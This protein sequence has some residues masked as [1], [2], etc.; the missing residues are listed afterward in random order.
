M[1]FKEQAKEIADRMD[2]DELSYGEVVDALYRALQSA[3][4]RGKVEGLKDAAGIIG[5][6]RPYN[7][8][9]VNRST[10]EICVAFVREILSRAAAL[11]QPAG[12]P[13]K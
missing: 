1:D 3:F 11:K 10:Q 9:P 7:G 2:R 13:G 8:L 12:G 4:E 5:T 6:S